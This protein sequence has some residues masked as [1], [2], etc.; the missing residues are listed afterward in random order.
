MNIKTITCHDVYN[1]GASLQA[2]ALQ[3]FLEN[4]GHS[5]E[6][7]DYL[8]NYKH[9][10][11]F[12]KAHNNGFWGKVYR[13]LPCLEPLCAT[14]QH[15]GWYRILPKIL[16][17]KKFKRSYLHCTKQKY[18]CIEDFKN[19]KPY[20][21]LYI[22]GSD[23]IWNTAFKNGLDPVYYCFFESDS[24]KCISYAASFGISHIP[25]E[26]ENF[27]K[28]GLSNFRYLSIRELSGVKLAKELGYDA[29]NVLD[30][31]FLL[32]REQW[33]EKI[34]HKCND[35]Y[36]LI[37][38]FSK[39]DD[40][41]KKIA[42]KIARKRNLKIY[43]FITDGSYIDKVLH[44]CGPIEFIEW[45]A[46]AEFIISN[47]F[48]ATA[49]SVILEKEF[50]TIPLL[51][52]DNSSRMADFLINIGLQDRFIEDFEK[53]DLQETI[54]YEPVE[55]KLRELIYVSSTWLLKA[56]ESTKL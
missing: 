41:I 55:R 30:P 2:Y 21:D 35:K 50:Y 27:V 51:G 4:N 23:Q 10:Y 29:V 33:V 44:S 9:F 52:Y 36:L 38:D 54:N 26:Y 24:N 1:F 34:K 14:I 12:F 13:E 3:T 53:I 8:P 6:V 56:I 39:N 48:H 31:V 22:A 46:N 7:I 42:I 18:Y 17:F 15:L 32:S 40:R 16:R 5:V 25:V 45:I 28:R 47:S 19:R 20:A 37:Y 11:A 49:F 43:S